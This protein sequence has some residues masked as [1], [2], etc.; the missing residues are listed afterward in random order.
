MTTKAKIMC[1][2]VGNCSL[3]SRYVCI[4]ERSGLRRTASIPTPVLAEIARVDLKGLR[5][6]HRASPQQSGGR[7]S[8]GCLEE[9]PCGDR[10]SST[11]TLRATRS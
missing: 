10:P 6:S 7:Q 9:A 11:A 3:S 4:P 1:I 5:V 8:F 2:I